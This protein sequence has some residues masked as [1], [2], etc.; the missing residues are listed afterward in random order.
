MS[1]TTTT[2]KTRKKQPKGLEGFFGHT[3]EDDD[4]VRAVQYQFTIL[5][6]VDADRWAVQLFSFL[7]GDP[8]IVKVFSEAYLLGNDCELYATKEDWH[9]AYEK[10]TKQEQWKRRA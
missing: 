8:T 3:F 10:R 5:R 4:G 6:R 2:P 7:D 1:K 9:W